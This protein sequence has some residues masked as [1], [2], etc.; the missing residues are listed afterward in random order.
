VFT[1]ADKDYNNVSTATYV[2]YCWA[3]I[4]G[5][6]KFGSYT[7]NGSDDGPF[8]YCGFRPAFV[9]LKNTTGNNWTI[10]D[11]KRDI[12]NVAKTRLFPSNS[13]AETSA[14]NNV[15]MLSNGFKLRVSG[16]T[17]AGANQN[18][19]TFIYAAFAEAPFKYAS[20]R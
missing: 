3:E 10:V 15:D 8:I 18:A 13:N 11:N 20:A 19:T 16:A 14:T 9:L 12:S 17:D 6:S 1:P 7:G 5:Y 2:N 4:A